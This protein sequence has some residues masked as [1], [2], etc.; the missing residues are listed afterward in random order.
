MIIREAE[1]DDIPVIQQLAYS[2]WP[3]V[4]K[5]IIT[6][7]QIEYM[8]HLLYSKEALRTQMLEQEH[9]FLI[10]ENNSKP[11]GFASFSPK[12]GN[13]NIFRLHKLYVLPALHRQGTGKML[14]E[15]I[16]KEI[17]KN[18]ISSI[19]LNVN[20]HNK[21]VLFYKHLGFKILYEEDIDIGN[22]FFMN[23]Y[24]MGWA[25]LPGCQMG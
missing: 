15:F 9:R 7:Q 22:G 18:Q 14:L 3:E 25:F 5:E 4:Y 23:D 12:P 21:A 17:N 2:I 16:L 10:A 20:R 1:P 19:E 6:S 24:V 13:E 8:L 11:S